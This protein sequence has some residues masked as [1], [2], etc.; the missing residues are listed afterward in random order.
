MTTLEPDSPEIAAPKRRRRRVLV[1]VAVA[2]L[3]VGVLGIRWWTSAEVLE[4]GVG[5]MTFTPQRLAEGP[6][7][8]G[9]TYPAVDEP[10]YD[11]T[12]TGPGRVTFARNSTGATATLQICTPIAD[13]GILGSMRG[14]LA[15]FCSALRPVEDGAHMRFDTEENGGEYVI[16]TV[17]PRKPGRTRVVDVALSYRLGA[18]GFFRRGTEHAPM[19]VVIPVR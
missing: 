10:A 6:T 1:A 4:P 2:G 14:D 16:L 19:D 5:G 7:Y 17:T 18:D 3:V 11:V 12:F 8:V 13:G 9:I 15:E